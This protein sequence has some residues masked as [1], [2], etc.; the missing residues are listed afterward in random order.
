MSKDRPHNAQIEYVKG[1]SGPYVVKRFREAG[2]FTAGQEANAYDS[3]RKLLNDVPGTRAA[4][5]LAVDEEANTLSLEFLEGL[6]LHER[7]AHGDMDILD[8]IRERLLRIF[9]RAR[10]TGFRFDSDPSNIL[11]ET[12]AAEKQNLVF[13]DPSCIPLP[14]RDHAFIVFMW[15][16]IKIPLRDWRVWRARK[17]APYWNAY[18]REYCQLSNI[19]G[20]SLAQQMTAYIDLVI[21]WN[22]ER[23]PV[24]GVLIHSFRRLV[25]IPIY[26]AIRLWF[27]WKPMSC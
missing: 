15:G 26:R 7:L 5:V 1:T 14:I 16:L 23:N 24:E 2:K 17:I 25:V 6:N 9:K 11:F 22:K 27:A 19:S 18:C 21:Q 12:D 4:R 13:V 3:L 8:N 20:A 10:D